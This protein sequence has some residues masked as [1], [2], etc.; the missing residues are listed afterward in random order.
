MTI[1]LRFHF[2]CASKKS[3]RVLLNECNIFLSTA[4]VSVDNILSTVSQEVV[5]LKFV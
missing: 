4:H 2:S 3:Y 5:N 1:A